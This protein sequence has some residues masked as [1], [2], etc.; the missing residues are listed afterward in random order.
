MIFLWRCYLPLA[1]KFNAPIIGTA[2]FFSWSISEITVGIPRLPSIS[3]T[4]GHYVKPNANFQERLWRFLYE[5]ENNILLYLETL[6]TKALYKELFPDQ[7]VANRNVSLLFVNN[8]ASLMPRLSVPNAISI[9]GINVKTA[10]LN[11]LP[12]VSF[13]FKLHDPFKQDFTY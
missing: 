7:D 4:V 3:L 2:P 5:V 6:K 12:K 8:H 9:G 11:P 1:R 13:N 10:K